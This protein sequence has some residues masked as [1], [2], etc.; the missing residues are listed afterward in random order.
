MNSHW[1]TRIRSV[2]C[3]LWFLWAE[4]NC[5]HF[6]Q[7]SKSFNVLDLKFIKWP[8]SSQF[9]NRRYFWNLDVFSVP[10]NFVE[11]LFLLYDIYL[12]NTMKTNL[13]LEFYETMTIDALLFTCENK[14]VSFVVVIW[15]LHDYLTYLSHSWNDLSIKSHWKW[16]TVEFLLVISILNTLS[17]N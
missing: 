14:P 6:R 17:S 1:I 15:G 8:L 16:L 7:C 12:Q 5:L 10:E 11:L 4:A 3:V 2:N 9:G 13:S